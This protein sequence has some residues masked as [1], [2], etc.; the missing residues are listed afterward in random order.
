MKAHAGTEALK[1]T[2]N[3]DKYLGHFMGI[4]NQALAAAVCCYALEFPVCHYYNLDCSV[5]QM[6]NFS[7][8]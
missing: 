5:H 7:A 6:K 4:Q 1:L 3:T 2:I 8:F